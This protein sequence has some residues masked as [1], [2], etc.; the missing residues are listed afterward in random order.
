MAAGIAGSLLLAIAYG[1]AIAASASCK[2][3]I[4]GA[5]V[6]HIAGDGTTCTAQVDTGSM[7]SSTAKA[8]ASGKSDASAEAS[9]SSTSKATASG[10]SSATAQASNGASAKSTAQT[11]SNADVVANGCPV[12]A[13][14][15]GASERTS[16]LLRRRQHQS[17]R[18]AQ[19]QRDGG[20]Q[21][22]LHTQ[23]DRKE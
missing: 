9:D 21:G 12:T 15:S 5:I 20:G 1:S 4:P 10:K 14:A 18:H 13:T 11:K 16:F 6:M 7:G 22:S 23:V 3:T 2:T 19:K 8:K 17:Y